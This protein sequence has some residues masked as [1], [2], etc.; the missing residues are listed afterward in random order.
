MIHTDGTSLLQLGLGLMQKSGHVDYYPNGGKNQPKCP[1]TSGIILSGIFNLVTV[2]VDGLL[3]QTI[4]NHM[5][6]VHFF[7]DTIV[8]SDCKYT[9]YPCKNQDE[10]NKGN[11]LSCS[12]FGC[13]QMGF[14][15]TKQ[16]D[17]GSLYLNTQDAD[18][19]PYCEHFYRVTLNSNSLSGQVQAKGVFKITFNGEKGSSSSLVLDNNENT[20][21]PGSSEK[22]LVPSSK[23]IGE[24][25]TGATL[26]YTK[27]QN[28]LI[29][30][31]YQNDWSFKNIEVLYGNSQ[32]YV[33][34]CPEK[35][36][37][38]SGSTLK[39]NKC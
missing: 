35:T 37:I 39:F 26:S 11:C 2:N 5:A 8:N 22:R 32:N 15:S 16:N 18:K 6:A 21:K 19:Y 36:Y 3:D 10:F 12:I 25:I 23:Y 28:L 31:V 4:C 33:T 9:A 34:L 20:F 17:Q 30:W 29:G 27:A 7:R 14:W 38:S 13:N 1:A 24:S